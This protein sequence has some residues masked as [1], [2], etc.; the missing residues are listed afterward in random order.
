[1]FGAIV[2]AVCSAAGQQASKELMSGNLIKREGYEGDPKT[3]ELLALNGYTGEEERIE[4][5]VQEKRYSDEILDEMLYSLEE[6][7]P[8]LLLGENTSADAIGKDLTFTGSFSDYP[9]AVSYKTDHPLLLSSDG[10]LHK[11]KLAEQ[12]N[13]RDGIPVRVNM[14]LT[15]ED[16]RGEISFYV[17]LVLQEEERD[18]SFKEVVN[19]AISKA[20]EESREE[21]Y[22]RLPEKLNETPV[23]YRETPSKEPF[24]ILVIGLVA[25]ILLYKREDDNLKE[26]VKKRN[27]QLLEDYP[28]IV[29]KFALFYSVGMTTKGIFLKLC[30]DYEETKRRKNGPG[31]RYVY[32]EML[33]TRAKMEEGIGEIAAYEDFARRCKHPKYRQLVNLM[34]QAVSKGKS[35]ISMTLSK[36][37]QRA[38]AE[39]KNHAKELGEEA[40]TKLLLPMFLMLLVVIIVIMV[41]AFLAFQ[42]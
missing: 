5:R 30:R 18:R 13:V 40:G 7:V 22:L 20:S 2:L 6:K 41:P 12:E 28:M 36:E 34:E 39:R 27:K 24:L 25:A 1:M 33:L 38:F 3:V 32:E 21:D 29:N 35:D 17:R 19:D 26:Q 8:G 9:F 4:V 14:M 15:C 31:F 11:D 23:S 16:Y 37:I 10:V 42:I